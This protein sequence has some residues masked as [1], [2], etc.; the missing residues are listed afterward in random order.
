MLYFPRHPLYSTGEN[1]PEEGHHPDHFARPDREIDIQT[2]GW[3]VGWEGG[4][5][6]GWLDLY[7]WN[8]FLKGVIGLMQITV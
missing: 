2:D 5:L 8:A 7:I 6:A 3:M 4:W 1:S